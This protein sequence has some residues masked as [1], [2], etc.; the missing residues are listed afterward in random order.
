MT[1]SLRKLF[2]GTV[3]L[4]VLKTLSESTMHGFG[5]SRALRDRSSDVI[6][7]K[8]AALYQALHRMER[9]GWIASEWGISD[10]QKR[11]KFYELTKAGK[12]RLAAEER[13]FR[14]YAEAVFKVLEPAGS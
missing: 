12:R 3:D 9:Q 11:A 6:V 14:R 4:L 7:L 5:I 8:D 10:A 1:D 2:P 13:L